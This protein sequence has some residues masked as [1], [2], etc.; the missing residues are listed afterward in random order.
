MQ[1]NYQRY[2]NL[3]GWASITVNLLLFILKYW[4]GI[5]T[6]SI[7]LIADAWH[8]LSDSVT[9]V[10][11]LIGFK[12]RDKPADKDHP[13]GHG[14][15]ELIASLIIGVLLAIIAFN[16][17]LE[18]IHILRNHVAANFGMIA[19]IVTALSVLV[20]EGMAQY[21][22]W[23]ARKIKSNALRADA[24]HHRSDALSSVII[25][26]GI[27]INP[28][29]WWID[30]VLGIAVAIFIFYTAYGIMADAINP[31]LGET[32]DPDIIAE[33]KQI[34]D[35]KSDSNT[36]VHHFHIHNYGDHTE[37]T[38]HIKLPGTHSLDQAHEIATQIENEIKSQL[39]ISATIH[40]EP[41]A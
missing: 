32:P 5:V 1:T 36:N 16:F 28:F 20:K 6:G 3:E 31:L 9:S 25:L 24:W 26:A 10:I 18:S 13:F 2:A 19:I 37:L 17:V 23:A 29:F 7:A 11:V 30:G 12:Y 35:E 40:M 34:C 15:A 22:F 39:N 21:A 8:T 4:A 14:R 41:T 27:F 33:I 38:F